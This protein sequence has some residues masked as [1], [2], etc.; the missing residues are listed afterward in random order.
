MITN[1]TALPTNDSL[2]LTS[3]FG[4]C[5][6]PQAHPPSRRQPHVFI[7]SEYAI[8]LREACFNLEPEERI[9]RPMGGRR[10]GDAR[11]RECMEPELTRA[12][13]RKNTPA[14]WIKKPPAR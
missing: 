10:S 5:F 11:V 14:L 2:R 8:S 6:L 9:E 4:E 12:L 3:D 13:G 7:H 1:S